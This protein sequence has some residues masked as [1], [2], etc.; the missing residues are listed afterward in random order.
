MAIDTVTTVPPALLGRLAG[1]ALREEALHTPKPGL[2]DRRGS[3]AH[4]DMTLPMLLTSADALTEPIAACAAA[5]QALPPGRDLRAV[6]GEIGRDG[7]RWMLDVT[8]GVN[9]HR[10]ALW[11]LGL[12]AAGLAAA[13][14]V[15]GAARFAA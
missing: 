2:V 3:G 10:G 6:I 11:A 15:A 8:G 14:T 12:L 9:T 1:R 4:R 7:E 13:G 5:A